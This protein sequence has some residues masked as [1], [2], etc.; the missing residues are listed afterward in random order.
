M[1]DEDEGWGIR[2]VCSTPRR[3]GLLN[4]WERYGAVVV[5]VDVAESL[6]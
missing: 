5:E 4:E 2:L 6:E 3:W 1:K